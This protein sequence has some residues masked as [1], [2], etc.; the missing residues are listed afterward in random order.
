MDRKIVFILLLVLLHITAVMANWSTGLR[1]A[2]DALGRRRRRSRSQRRSRSSSSGTTG[3]SSRSSM[4][5]RRRRRRSSNE[6][7]ESDEF[8]SEIADALSA[9]EMEE[10]MQ[11]IMDH[12]E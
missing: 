4:R 3:S 12:Q 9:A 6:E 10:V 2:A 1:C 7:I 8:A 5:R 11:K